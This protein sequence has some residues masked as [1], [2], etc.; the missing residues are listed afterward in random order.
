MLVFLALG[1]L[2]F[3]SGTM[4]QMR[5][6]ANVEKTYGLGLP[7]DMDKLIPPDSDYPVY[8]LKPGQEAY[9]DVDGYKLKDMIKQITAFSLQS[10][11][12]GDQFWGRIIGTKYH[13]AAEEWMAT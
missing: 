11:D 5:P 13:L 3:T 7:R 4:A 1:G 9:K 12:A 6:G 8:P 10:L 2:L